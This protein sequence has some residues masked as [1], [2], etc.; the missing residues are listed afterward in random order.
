MPAFPVPSPTL[1]E[2]PRS[3]QGKG[4]DHAEAGVHPTSSE[5]AAFTVSQPAAPRDPA[6]NPREAPSHV[7]AV[8]SLSV[9][10]EVAFSVHVP[11]AKPLTGVCKPLSAALTS[12]TPTWLTPYRARR[13]QRRRSRSV[14]EASAFSTFREA[15]AHPRAQPGEASSGPAVT[16][17]AATVL[18]S[19]SFTPSVPGLADCNNGGLSSPRPPPVKGLKPAPCSLP[20]ASTTPGTFAQDGA[21]A[22]SKGLSQQTP[23]A[24][25]NPPPQP[26]T[27]KQP[28]QATA[29]QQPSQQRTA[30]VKAL[31]LIH[32]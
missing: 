25:R 29:E 18:T 12:E 28:P 17:A 9:S 24:V 26:L 31:S 10:K 19:V 13:P 14:G 21:E 11:A 8:R 7:E 22:S 20:P 4:Q 3:K 2:A 27:P 23:P 15:H 1:K 16:P 5:N 30:P 6:N 32:I